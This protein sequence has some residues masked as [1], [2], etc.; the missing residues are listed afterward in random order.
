MKYSREKEESKLSS[1]L[2]Q[3]VGPVGPWPYHFLALN[4]LQATHTLARL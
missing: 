4:I 1:G 2:V 3:A